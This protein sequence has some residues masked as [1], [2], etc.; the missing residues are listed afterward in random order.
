MATAK[1]DAETNIWHLLRDEEKKKTH[2]NEK[3]KHSNGVT[4]LI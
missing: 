2:I 3:Q 4:D 1:T